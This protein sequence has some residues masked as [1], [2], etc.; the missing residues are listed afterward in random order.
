MFSFEIKNMCDKRKPS[1]ERILAVIWP[2]ENI[3]C[4]KHVYTRYWT[5]KEVGQV[6]SCVCQSI[7]ICALILWGCIIIY[8]NRLYSIHNLEQHLEYHSKFIF[9]NKL[10]STNVNL[11]S[12]GLKSNKLVT[13]SNEDLSNQFYS[14]IHWF[15]LLT[16]MQY[17]CT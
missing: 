13:S 6:F 15:S 10:P 17:C 9:A 14:N 7:I 5:M 16:V 3:F 1:S 4:L 8:G 12:S 2:A 11:F